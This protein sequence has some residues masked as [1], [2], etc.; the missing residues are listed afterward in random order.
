[1]DQRQ[2]ESC[3]LWAFALE[4]LLY[5]NQLF[6]REREQ[7]PTSQTKRLAE[8][9]PVVLIIE[10][11]HVGTSGGNLIIAPVLSA[12]Q[13]ASPLEVDQIVRVRHNEATRCQALVLLLAVMFRPLFA[14]AAIGAHPLI[15]RV[16][17]LHLNQ[18]FPFLVL[19][20]LIVN[21]HRVYDVST[22]ENNAVE[23]NSIKFIGLAGGGD[24]KVLIVDELLE[25][26]PSFFNHNGV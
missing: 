5:V 8:T 14:V 12:R 9:K 21:E 19:P 6:C 3:R 17:V 24:D 22:V 4:N 26:L 25:L 20:A 10:V 18:F 7:V 15:L 23:F 13:S 16:N 11:S 1:M 2:E